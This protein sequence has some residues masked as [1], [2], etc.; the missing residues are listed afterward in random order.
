NLQE[1]REAHYATTAKGTVGVVGM[2]SID[3]STSPELARG[4]GATY[5]V[6][7]RGGK[8]GLNALRLNVSNI[9][10][11]EQMQGLRKIR[12]SVYARRREVPQPV[13]DIP[14]NEPA[15]RL[16]LFGSSY[17]VGANPGDLTYEMNAADLRDILWSIK[18][19]KEYSDFLIA[20]IH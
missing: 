19:G 10:T 8:P 5:A 11:A 17:K 7:T 15:D 14:A 20:A 6:G 9:V 1:A 16:S 12:D 18:N 2:F 13:N 3:A 4:S